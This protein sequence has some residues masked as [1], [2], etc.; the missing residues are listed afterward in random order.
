MSIVLE[1]EYRKNTNI[2]NCF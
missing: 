1:N 2:S